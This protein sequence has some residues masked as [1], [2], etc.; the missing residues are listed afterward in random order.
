MASPVYQL[1]VFCLQRTRRVSVL[2]QN[3][4]GKVSDDAF[5]M[6]IKMKVWIGRFD[7]SFDAMM[8][9]EF[10]AEVFQTQNFIIPKCLDND[11]YASNYDVVA[12]VK[13]WG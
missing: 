9:E 10:L 2:I 11:L 13:I 12:V 5:P 8:R 3:V 4:G 6:K 1:R 7:V